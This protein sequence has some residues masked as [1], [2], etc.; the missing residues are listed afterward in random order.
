MASVICKQVNPEILRWARETAGYRRDKED[1]NNS[2]YFNQKTH[3]GRK[4]IELVLRKYNQQQIS[5][6]EAADYLYINPS[7]FDQLK[8]EFSSKR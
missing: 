3:L 8:N 7:Q 4:Y 1:P 5:L 2:L 6:T